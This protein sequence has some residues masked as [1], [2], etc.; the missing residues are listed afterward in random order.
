MKPATAGRYQ[1]CVPSKLHEISSVQW[2]LSEPRFLRRSFKS[3][4]G[5]NLELWQSCASSTRPNC[6]S[7]KSGH[8][9]ID[10]KSV[11][12]V[13]ICPATIVIRI[14]RAATGWRDLSQNYCRLP[15]RSRQALC[16]DSDDSGRE[17]YR[18]CCCRT[19]ECTRLVSLMYHACGFWGM[20]S[21]VFSQL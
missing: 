12:L 2:I 8:C 19:W 14:E 5:N 18:E 10:R 20:F 11:P 21:C 15:A 3:P 7:A 13:L 9:V 6:V 4:E 1:E 17:C 16:D